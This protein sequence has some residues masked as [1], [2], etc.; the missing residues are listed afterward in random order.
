MQPRGRDPADVGVLTAFGVVSAVVMV[1]AYG[2]EDR[3]PIWVAVFAAGCLSTAVYGVITH[4]W[5]FA[6]LEAIWSVL[7][8][9][10]FSRQRAN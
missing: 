2:L 5:V 1:V 3:S 6:V 4:A 10:R 8:V 7:A 9:H